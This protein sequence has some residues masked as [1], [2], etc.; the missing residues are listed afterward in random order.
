[1]KVRVKYIR[2]SYHDDHF[3]LTEGNPLVGKTLAMLSPHLGQVTLARSLEL[4]GWT[5]YGKWEQ[6]TSRLKAWKS[7]PLL[8]QAVSLC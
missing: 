4:L 2:N 6:A 5:L 3:D 1:M 8:K 7:E